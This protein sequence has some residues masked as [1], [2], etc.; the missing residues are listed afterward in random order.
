M[1]RDD[2]NIKLM[3]VMILNIIAIVV[4]TLASIFHLV[5]G[6]IIGFIVCFLC[7]LSAIY[8]LVRIIIFKKRL[9]RL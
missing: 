9:N 8:W 5:Y 4:C 7:D 1:L 2:L 3:F 6:N